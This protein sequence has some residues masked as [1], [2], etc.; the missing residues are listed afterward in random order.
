MQ[1]PHWETTNAQLVI[2]D[3]NIA[4]GNILVR[5]RIVP[6]VFGTANLMTYGT[7]EDQ[8]AAKVTVTR[9]GGG[10]GV[11]VVSV[12]TSDG[13][14][15]NGV[16]YTGFT[17]QLQWS[18]GVTGPQTISIPIKQDFVVTS[19]LMFNL[20]LFDTT[21]GGAASSLA[22]G[23]VYTNAIVT[24]TNLDAAGTLHFNLSSYTF[25]KNGGAAIISIVRSGGMAGT[26]SAM[27]ATYDGSAHSNTDYV[28]TNG[29]ITFANGEISKN[30]R[31]PIIDNSVQEGNLA[32]ALVLTNASPT[33]ALGSPNL[34]TLNIL[35]DDT[36][37]QP[38]GSPD[39]TYSPAAGFNGPVFA[40]ALEPSDGKL[41]VGGSFTQANGVGRRR[42]ARMNTDGTLDAKF[43]SYVVTQGSQRYHTIHCGSDRWPDTRW[44]FVYQFQRGLI[45]P[46]C[47][48][49]LQ[50]FGGQFVHSR[51]GGR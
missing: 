21:V 1:F 19:N 9:Q 34:A 28:A 15:K 7:N 38:P 44:R 45:Q 3:N 5:W 12:G 18:S 50:R 33:N 23:G 32:L 48:F 24:I 31:V 46:H 26:V 10:I 8:A 6:V 41:L 30:F 13:T 27:F 43:S 36:Y 39:P 11:L 49:K 37:N 20:R 47:P 16:N 25:D 22:L 40:L 42:I 2:I 4:S 29:I 51:F 17:N 14:A 35:D